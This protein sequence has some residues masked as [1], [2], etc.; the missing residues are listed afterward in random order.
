MQLDIVRHAVVPCAGDAAGLLRL[1]GPARPVVLL[2]PP[3]ALRD[4]VLAHL[5][6]WVGALAVDHSA[7]DQAP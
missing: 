1:V 5:P 7:G 4:R 2:D 6:A 3:V